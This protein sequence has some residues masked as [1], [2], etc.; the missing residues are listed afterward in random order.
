MSVLQF[1]RLYF[2]GEV[3]W[4]PGLANNFGSLFDPQ[5]VQLL[6]DNL[7]PEQAKQNII[8]RMGLGQQE[9]GIWNYYGT[10]HA[11]F[12]NVTIT[13]G[14]LQQNQ[15]IEQGDAVLGK[16][17]SLKG[18]LVDLDAAKANCSQIFYDE[19]QLGD[20]G[21]GIRALQTEPMHARWINFSRNLNQDQVLQIAGSAGVV[22]QGEFEKSKLNF[23]GQANSP[24]LEAFA[25]EITDPDVLGIMIRFHTYRTLY[26]QNG[27]RNN[28]PQQPRSIA[29]LKQLYNTGANFSNP[30]YSVL[31]GVIGLWHATDF[32]S[33]PGKRALFLPRTALGAA[34][35]ALDETAALL[36]VDLGASIPEASSQLEKADLGE[37]VITT[38]V[39]GQSAQV[40][41]IPF[42]GYNRSNYEKTAGIIDISLSG[43]ADNDI[44]R[45]IK[46]GNLAITFPEVQGQPVLREANFVAV[47]E[48][49]NHYLD[50]GETRQVPVKVT[51]K[52]EP[53]NESISVAVDEYNRNGRLTKHIT[54]LVCDAHGMVTL[55]ISA[56]APGFR[57]FRFA[58]F[59]TTDGRPQQQPQLDSGY[60]YYVNVRTLPFEDALERAT[61]DNGLTWSFMYSRIFKLYDVL[62]PVMSRQGIN[63]P[64]HDKDRMMTLAS[65]LRRV[66]AKSGFNTFLHMPV[67]RDMSAGKR[68][69]VERWAI[70]VENGEN[71][72]E[73]EFVVNFLDEPAPPDPRTLR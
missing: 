16:K 40:A 26:F 64:L 14:S 52:G 5:N 42:A 60:D 61:P 21:L 9:L 36:S 67:T 39:N 18:M 68:K 50:E 31:T 19:M 49:R 72:D 17:I 73:P 62:N 7:P 38:E 48:Q 20:A 6:I 46:E 34:V 24:L 30:A 58:P 59:K 1:P 33:M 63:V 2:K 57:A 69:L 66:M 25:N 22:W 45:K 28:I 3:S 37:L 54:V 32:K 8:D 70:L 23:S 65:R 41:T 4:D 44:V 53:A 27:L 55:P 29:Q 56:E 47:V 10:H 71:P 15:V 13:G 11:I 51:F 43:H 35:V 12:E